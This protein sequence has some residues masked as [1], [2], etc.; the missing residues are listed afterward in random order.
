MKWTGVVN[1]K[2]KTQQQRIHSYVVG[3]DGLEK[4]SYYYADVYS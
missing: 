2:K 3:P 4:K 1:E